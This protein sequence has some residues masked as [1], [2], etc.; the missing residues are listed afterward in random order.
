MG[1]L[2]AF[3]ILHILYRKTVWFVLSKTKPELVTELLSTTPS[4]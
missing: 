4:K 3:I 1:R 2:D